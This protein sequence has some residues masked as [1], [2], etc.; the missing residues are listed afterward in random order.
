MS[1][2]SLVLIDVP[3]LSHSSAPSVPSSAEKNR[4]PF[5]GVN[6]PGLVSEAPGLMS[7]TSVVPAK[8]PSLLHSSAPWVPS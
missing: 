4:V 6:Q 3:R 7:L 8:V 2:T 5:T 1:L